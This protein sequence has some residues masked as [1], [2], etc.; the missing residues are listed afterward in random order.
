[1]EHFWKEQNNK[2]KT[3]MRELGTL[4]T[5]GYGQSLILKYVAQA[6][7]IA[8]KSSRKMVDQHLSCPKLLMFEL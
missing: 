5:M 4:R 8:V 7:L 3:K 6:N 2:I 1:V